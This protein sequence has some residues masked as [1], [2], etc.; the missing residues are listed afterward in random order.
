M[1]MYRNGWRWRVVVAAFTI[2]LSAV[3]PR[4]VDAQ[5]LTFV[6][7][8]AYC[9]NAGQMNQVAGS[10]ASVTNYPTNVSYPGYSM[11]VVV[12]SDTIPNDSC[13]AG[14]LQSDG[15]TCIGV[16]VAMSLNAATSAGVQRSG[17]VFQG[18]VTYTHTP[19][20]NGVAFGAPADNFADC[21]SPTPCPPAGC[22]TPV[23]FNLGTSN[24]G[25]QVQFSDAAHGVIFDITGRGV[26]DRVAWPVNADEVGFLGID[27]NHNGV[28][29]NGAELVGG[30]L[31]EGS[32]GAW[33]ALTKLAPKDVGSLT[34]GM[35]LFDSL[36][37]WIDRNRD[38]ISTPDEVEPASHYLAKVW[39]SGEWVGKKDPNGNCYEWKG[40]V[41]YVDHPE[42]MRPVYDVTVAVQPQ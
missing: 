5:H 14:V 3:C 26:Y 10:Y 25:N 30:A 38:G 4:G 12:T 31:R 8:P 36:V 39:L 42:V 15:R 40:Y 17:T 35:A 20:V 6:H 33:D 16:V 37:V 34:P 41:N 21:P 11:T 27:K 28:I 13:T 29:D 7:G 22:Q 1:M 19:Y 32:S 24:R 2:M 23:V 18:R 9:E